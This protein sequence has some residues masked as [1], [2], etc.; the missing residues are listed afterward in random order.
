MSHWNSSYMPWEEGS[1]EMWL[2]NCFARL[3]IPWS[4]ENMKNLL[5]K[6]A[7]KIKNSSS[8]VVDWNKRQSED[9]ESTTSTWSI[10]FREPKEGKRLNS[11]DNWTCK[12]KSTWSFQSMIKINKKLSEKPSLKSKEISETG[13]CLRTQSWKEIT[14]KVH[15]KA[16]EFNK[17]RH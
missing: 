2:W 13:P 5:L 10:K 8:N 17:F 1:I 3:S 16:E 12:K 7:R 9:Q 15:K 11:K 4:L 6:W 14:C